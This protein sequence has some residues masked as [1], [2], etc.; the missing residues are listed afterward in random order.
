RE[1]FGPLRGRVFFVACGT[2]NNGGDGFVAA[3]Y[4]AM[5]GADVQLK[6]VGDPARISGDARTHFNL[7]TRMGV[8][9]TADSPSG[10]AVK[11]DALLGTGIK[12]APRPDVAAAVE[13]LNGAGGPT[14]AVDIPSG[15]DS[16]T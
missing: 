11:I 1:R 2:G 15:V 14:I 10:A 4:L 6:I 8:R 7:L 13:A 16:D 5:A 3:R 9:H 12:G